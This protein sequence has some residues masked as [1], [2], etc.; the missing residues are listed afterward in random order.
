M[1]RHLQSKT[2][3]LA[4]KQP[5]FIK[6]DA[7]LRGGIALISQRTETILAE[8]VMDYTLPDGTRLNAGKDKVILRGDAGL[9]AWA[10][11]IYSLGDKEYV[12]CPDNEVLGYEFDQPEW[13][14]EWK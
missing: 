2:G 11:K 7:Q 10:K 8:L 12:L 13:H 6:P 4:I 1:G 3:M 9:N 14:E 5:Q